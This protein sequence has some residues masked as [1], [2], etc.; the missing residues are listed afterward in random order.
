MVKRTVVLFFSL[1]LFFAVPESKSFGE[2]A[3]RLSLSDCLNIAL[4]DNI[5]IKI[6]KIEAR[7]AEQNVLIAE[8]V[9]DALIAGKTTYSDDQRASPSPLMGTKTITTEYG[10]GI[11]KELP[12]GTE[13]SID[14]LDTREWTDRLFT[15]LNPFHEA[16]LSFTL[17]QPVLKNFFGYVD[18]SSVRLSKIEANMADL[19]ALNRIEN[20]IAEIEKAYWY[21]VFTYQ[22]VSL[23]EGLLREATELYELFK[24]HLK[25]G[26][27]EETELYETE[28]NMR[29]R[30]AVL[31]VS[32]N[33][34]VTASN[35]LKL[36]LNEEGDFTIMPVDRLETFGEKAD[37]V[38]SM[39]E[40]F[41]SNREYRIKK[42]ELVAKKVTLS[43]KENSLWPVVDLVGTYS[44]NGIARKTQKANRDITAENNPLYYGGVE[45]RI[46]IENRDA[47]GEYEKAK[48]EKKKVVLELIYVEKDI[49]TL[50]DE[51]VRNVNLYLENAKRWA[52]I[53]EIQYR[54]FRD[55][56][57]KLKYGRSSSKDV[58]DYQ[59]DFTLAAL[60]EY[61]AILEYYDAL[62]D[63]ENAKDTLLAKVGVLSR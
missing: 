42:K 9:F 45:F 4:A 27:V 58:V 28:A 13:V 39:N 37:L 15:D 31:L 8:S 33:N 62:I 36:L 11:S 46:P 6:A 35:N 21:L 43:M 7:M 16:G 25:T 61:D 48:L 22:D 23:R 51:K 32:R 1:F 56:E 2:E 38:K 57:K 34:L 47:R 60:R 24:K 29:T 3:V 19:K 55:Q 14:Y 41:I 52:L 30:K 20:T 12:T 26:L 50:I 54:K 63:L 53:K 49:A 5:D 17:R 44:I 40:A 59:N 18:R 10:A